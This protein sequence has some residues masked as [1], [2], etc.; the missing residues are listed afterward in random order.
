M[1]KGPPGD[2]LSN[3]VHQATGMVAAQADCDIDE[4][5][6]LMVIRAAATQVSLE[7][8]ALDVLDHRTLFYA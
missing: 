7:D 5:L 1:P 6:Q 4:A 2:H 3:H 8:L